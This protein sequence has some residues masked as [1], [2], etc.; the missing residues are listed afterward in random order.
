VADAL[1]V[2][3]ITSCVP[4]PELLTDD[5]LAHLIAIAVQRLLGRQLPV[6]HDGLAGAAGRHLARPG[7]VTRPCDGQQA[8]A[9][10]V[11]AWPG[12]AAQIGGYR[13]PAL[14]AY[15]CDGVEEK[16]GCGG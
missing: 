10:S 1:G 4:E 14:L 11:S 16:L 2:V 15:G 5:E 6:R 8:D 7:S 3:T 12:T 9:V 13:V